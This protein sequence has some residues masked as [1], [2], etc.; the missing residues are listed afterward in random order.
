MDKKSE[1]LELAT[2]AAGCFWG[3]ED[4]FRQTKGV[5]NTEVGYTGGNFPNPTYEN[6]CSGKTNH[7]EAVNVWFDKNEVSYENLLKL[8]WDIHNPTQ[9]NAQGPDHGSQYRSVIFYHN[10][11]QK[12]SAEKSKKEIESSHKYPNPI[13]TSIEPAKEFYRAEEYHQQYVEK[14]GRRICH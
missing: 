8:F 6:V 12:K 4:S 11:N 9:G 2:F 13:T 10:E 1:K 14:T 3:I 5:K 7:A